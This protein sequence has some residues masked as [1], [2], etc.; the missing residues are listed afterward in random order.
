MRTYARDMTAFGE[1]CAAE[2][3]PLAYHHHMA[4]VVETEPE[5]ETEPVSEPETV[6][7]HSSPPPTSWK[8]TVAPLSTAARGGFPGMDEQLRRHAEAAR[9][10]MPPDEG[11]A[12]QAAERVADG[13]L[14]GQRRGHD[15]QEPGPGLT[16]RPAPDPQRPLTSIPATLGQSRERNLH[17]RC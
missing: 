14:P 4:A 17:S 9:G 1:W 7:V 3:M 2:G 11:L 5:L 6:A 16:G 8:V 15:H 12:L 13:Q 10:F